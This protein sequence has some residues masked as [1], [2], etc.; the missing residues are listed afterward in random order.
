MKLTNEELRAIINEEIQNVVDEGFLDR[1]KGAAG[2]L[3]QKLGFG[4]KK[5]AQ[6]P[7]AQTKEK[8]A[9]QQPAAQAK[10]EPL[11]GNV[12]VKANK[13]INSVDQT[14]KKYSGKS[15]INYKFSAELVMDF[16]GDLG[17]FNI[18]GFTRALKPN[19][20]EVKIDKITAA[21]KKNQGIN[22]N[23][24]S[25]KELAKKLIEA[26]AAD[27]LAAVIDV[28]DYLGDTILMFMNKMSPKK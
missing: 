24:L 27:E 16:V 2:K 6:Q 8:P 19:E 12:V 17:G 20:V 25:I 22:A 18:Q 14:Y 3:G 5:A 15:L 21:I 28:I 1:I 11:S 10:K 4:K 26:G 9:A 23:Q 7:A 13:L